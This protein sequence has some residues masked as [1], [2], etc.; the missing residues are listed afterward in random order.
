MLF[1]VFI[2]LIGGVLTGG[3]GYALVRNRAFRRVAER[4]AGEVTDRAR[5]TNHD[6]GG[7]RSR[8]TNLTVVFR[9]RDGR[10]VQTRIQL[11]DTR[12][13]PGS[14]VRVL[15]D[16]RDPE[17]TQLDTLVGRGTCWMVP[18]MLLGL[19]VFAGGAQAVV[20]ALIT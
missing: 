9:T 8:T 18:G 15:Y 20:R 19:A 12:I 17:I 13:R 14:Q 4:A 11:G 1:S 10:R 2:T 7:Q 6:A 5:H 16:P 3:F